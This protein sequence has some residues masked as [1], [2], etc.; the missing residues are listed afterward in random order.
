MHDRLFDYQRHLQSAQLRRLAEGLGLD[1]R[2]FSKGLEEHLHVPRLRQNIT[3]GRSLGV[4]ATFSL[5]ALRHAVA[6]ALCM[7][8]N[9]STLLRRTYL[10]ASAPGR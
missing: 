8:R 6:S 5:L 9:N 10:A 1:L 3:E 7:S 2:R 4:R